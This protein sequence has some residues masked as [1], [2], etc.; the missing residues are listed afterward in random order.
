MRSIQH[1]VSALWLAAMVACPLPAGA[2]EAPSLGAVEAIRIATEAYIYGYPLVTFDMARRQQ[3]NVA[4]PDAE[5]APMGQVITMRTLSRRRQPL[6]LRAQCR[7][8]VHRGVA[9]RVH[10]ALDPWHPRHGRPVLHRADAGRLVGRVQG[11]EPVHDGEQGPDVRHHR[12]GLERHAPEGRDAGQSPT[13]MVWV[14]GRI[15]STGT[16]EDYQ[17]VH[18]LQDKFTVVPLSAYGKPYTPPPGAVDPGFDMQTGVR[19]LVNALDVDAYFGRLAELMKTNP[20]TAQDAPIVARM[21]KIGLVPG[22]DFDPAKLGFLDREAIK[23][24]PK[25]A[26]VEMGL[27]LKKQKTTNGWLYFTKGV[28]NFGT[29]YL[30]RGMANLLGPGWNRPQDAVY[31]LSQKDASGDEYNGEKHKYVVRFEKGQ[32]PPAEAFWSITMYDSDFFFVPN[33]INRYDLAQRDKLVA[34]PDGSVDMY[35]QAESPGKDREANWLPAPKGKFVPRDAH[36]SAEENAAFDPRRLLDAA[37]REAGAVEPQRHGLGDDRNWSC[38]GHAPQAPLAGRAR[39]RGGAHGRRVVALAQGRPRLAVRRGSLSLRLP[40]P[41]DGPDQG[42]RHR[43]A[44]G[45]RVRRSGQPVRGDD[46]LPRR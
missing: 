19:K 39:R 26:L 37:A 36:L 23:V 34:N 2:D 44:D 46:A 33:P 30:T 5:H 17:A 27:H 45:G 15:Y 41:D 25:L 11:G 22:K 28:G 14:L 9:R 1:A 4:A 32:L 3:T 24:V 42:S 10:R 20:P 13:G 21:A 8:A 6:L 12:A 16:P 38:S 31:P 7:H 29:G 18:A 35:V 40:A 43:R